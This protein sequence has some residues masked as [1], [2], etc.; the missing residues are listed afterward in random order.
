MWKSYADNHKGICLKFKF[1]TLFNQLFYTF[2]VCY[3]PVFSALDLLDN[4]GSQ[5][6]AV[7]QRW[8]F[9]KR[10]HYRH[11]REVRLCSHV[12]KG[13]HAIDKSFITGIHFG[14]KT[15][16]NSKKQIENIGRDMDYTLQI[17]D[18]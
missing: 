1:P 8:L 18:L 4:D 6:D 17:K 11:E 15:T 7:V 13:I 9:T 5:I 10:S 3:D 16:A 14:K 2:Q 12:L